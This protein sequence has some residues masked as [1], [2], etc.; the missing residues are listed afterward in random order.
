MML[1]K[2]KLSLEYSF[3]FPFWVGRAPGC[4]NQHP[5]DVGV[6]Q[7]LS[8]AGGLSLL[9]AARASLLHLYV[10]LTRMTL[11]AWEA[12]ASVSQSHGQVALYSLSRT[13]K[14]CLLLLRFKYGSYKYFWWIYL[15]KNKKPRTHSTCIL[16]HFLLICYIHLHGQ[17]TSI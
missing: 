12:C 17:N 13:C 6:D 16:I 1:I 8:L 11:S 2:M 10:H 14:D 3:L 4:S 9:F 15:P 7:L 5:P